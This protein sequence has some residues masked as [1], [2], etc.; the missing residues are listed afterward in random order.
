MCEGFY[1]YCAFYYQNI[2]YRYIIVIEYMVLDY[3]SSTY[4]CKLYV[5]FAIAAINA[6]IVFADNS[7]KSSE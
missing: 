4:V 5:L 6:V 1:A 7:K 3:W 2:V